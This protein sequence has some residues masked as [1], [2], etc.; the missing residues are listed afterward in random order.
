MS[1]TREMRPTPMAPM[2]MRLLGANWPNTL[3]G[4]MAGKPATAAAPMLD[5]RKPR[6]DTLRTFFISCSVFPGTWL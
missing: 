6:R 4:T 3:A 1:C 2:L 5:L